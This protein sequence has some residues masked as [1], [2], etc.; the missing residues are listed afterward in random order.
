MASK[1]SQVTGRKEKGIKSSQ[2]LRVAILCVTVVTLLIAIGAFVAALIAAKRSVSSGASTASASLSTSAAS[3][4]VDQPAF[5][6]CQRMILNAQ[7]WEQAVNTGDSVTAMSL[8]SPNMTMYHNNFYGTPYGGLWYGFDMANP[9]NLFAALSTLNSILVSAPVTS[10]GT[11]RW[12]CQ[13]GVTTVTYNNVVTF[14]CPNNPSI[15]SAPLTSSCIDRFEFDAEG[16][17]IVR[18]ESFK[19]PSGYS[20][21][22]VNQCGYPSTKAFGDVLTIGGSLD[23]SALQVAPPNTAC[24]LKIRNSAKLRQAQLALDFAT[25]IPMLDLDFVLIEHA[26][27]GIP[28]G[29]AWSLAQSDQ[30]IALFL[31]SVDSFTP[32]S[33]IVDTWN[34]DA[35]LVTL[36]YTMNG[37]FKC[38]PNSPRNA[39]LLSPSTRCACLDTFVWNADGTKAKLLETH[40]DSTEASLFYVN[41]CGLPAPSVLP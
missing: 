13:S 21:F 10:V 24:A 3:V 32:A 25:I 40:I 29:G 26:H 17:H 34:C 19:D 28:F 33:G 11:P 2:V 12:N 30:F 39:G 8:M 37:V 9:R 23:S 20:L 7:L 18:F 31:S 1:Y 41:T 15:V 27:Y 16:T 35:S 5:G 38:P 4:V 36:R 14:R 22:F 6:A